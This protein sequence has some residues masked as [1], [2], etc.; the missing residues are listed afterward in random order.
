M[1]K[2]LLIFFYLFSLYIGTYRP[3]SKKN[4]DFNLDNVCY[5]KD[6]SHNSLFEYVRPCE[7]EKTCISVDASGS[8]NYDVKTCQDYF[9]YFRTMG[10]DC[11]TNEDCDGSL[12][13]SDK[14]CT[15]SGNTAY[16][17]NSHYYCPSNK[18][19]FAGANN[20]C[21]ED[22]AEGNRDKCEVNSKTTSG[23]TITITTDFP[24]GSYFE[25][26]YFKMCGYISLD[27]KNDNGEYYK[28]SVS[29]SEFCSVQDGDFVESD[30]ACESGFALYFYGN[31][32]YKLTDNPYTDSSN[33]T[34][35]ANDKRQD[36]YLRC[37]TVT[38]IDTVKNVIKYKIGSGEEE[39]YHLSQVYGD[40][41]YSS[42][43]TYSNYRGEIKGKINQYTM[44]KLELFQKYKERYNAIK[45][46]CMNHLYPEELYTCRDNELRKWFYFY[47]NPKDYLLYR[48]EPQVMDYLVQQ[49]YKTYTSN[50]SGFF[51]NLSFLSLL[52]ILI[53]F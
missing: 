14:K 33:P 2:Q 13:C 28:K 30:F 37:V 8:T 43:L 50:S 7:S 9:N 51:L 40:L 19:Y 36:M 45:S 21:D 18:Y 22:I 1:K 41:Y 27:S 5:Y 12:I 23:T 38:G 11:T 49:Y 29:I 26:G 15:F 20:I 42:S 48:N 31:G 25:P 35:D 53:S 24:K 34:L 46:D 3:M 4:I 6:I 47:T 32:G 16:L 44:T 10:D 39:Y 17:C 52:L